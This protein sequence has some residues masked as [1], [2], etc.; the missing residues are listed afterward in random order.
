MVNPTPRRD[1]PWG[2]MPFDRPYIRVNYQGDGD[3]YRWL[4][5]VD[6][7]DGLG[8]SPYRCVQLAGNV[9]EWC[10]DEYSSGPGKTSEPPAWRICRGGS[11]G[12]PVTFLRCGYRQ[13]LP[14]QSFHNDLGFR[15]VLPIVKISDK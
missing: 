6:A 10:R 15:C 8:D 7:F 1:Y 12:D 4:A 5:P 11:W 14:S 3:G 9:W 2:D 13:A